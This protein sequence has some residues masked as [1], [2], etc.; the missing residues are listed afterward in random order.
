MLRIKFSACRQFSASKSASSP[1]AKTLAVIVSQNAEI[2]RKT[3][4]FMKKI[5][6]LLLIL[7]S[8]FAFSQDFFVYKISKP[9]CIF[10]FMETATNGNGTSSYFKKYIEDK[11]QNNLNFKN[12]CEEYKKINLSYNYKRY[13]FPDERRPNRSTY[14]LISIIAV[15]S[16]NLKEFK[17]STIGILPI[18]EYQ[19]LFIFIQS[20]IR[21]C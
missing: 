7:V 20:F 17:E 3:E 15:N 12:L 10:N 13:E 4:K 18:I 19:K 2:K 8:N 1:S 14:D 6:T 5:I 16:K 9:Y 21:I 11:T